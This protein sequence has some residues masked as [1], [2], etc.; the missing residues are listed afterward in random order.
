MREKGRST[1]L[2]SRRG[3]VNHTFLLNPIP[4][5]DRSYIVYCDVVVPVTGTGRLLCTVVCNIQYPF[6]FYFLPIRPSDTIRR[7]LAL[8]YY[9]TM[10][11]S[12]QAETFLSKRLISSY[13]R[14]LNALSL[15]RHT[16]DR[17]IST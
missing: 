5:P 14:L 8:D 1:C 10:T 7:L 4:E 15:T 2:Y 9:C 13:L 3:A 16:I 6:S 11:I 12:F 17:N